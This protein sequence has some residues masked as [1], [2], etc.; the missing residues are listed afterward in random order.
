MIEQD[1][2]DSRIASLESEKN[3]LSTYLVIAG[4]ALFILAPLF[5]S[6]NNKVDLQSKMIDSC[7]SEI[8]DLNSA[9]S[10]T[11]DSLDS[12]STDASNAAGDDYDV[13]SDTLN[14]LF[15]Q[16]DDAK[17]TGTSDSSIC[18]QVS[19]SSESTD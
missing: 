15:S 4:I 5:F 10:S 13:Q 12:I 1:Y 3:K 9:I 17:K 16:A 11:N 8:S 18:E 2:K 19:T 14:D 6:T 7:I